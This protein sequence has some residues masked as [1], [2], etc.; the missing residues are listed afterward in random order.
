MEDINLDEES[1]KF[2]SPEIDKG[3]LYGIILIIVAIFTLY[4]SIITHQIW[5]SFFIVIPL[6]YISRKEEEEQVKKS[7]KRRF[8]NEFSKILKFLFIIIIIG[9]IIVLFFRIGFL[10]TA[11]LVLISFKFYNYFSGVITRKRFEK[12]NKVKIEAL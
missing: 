6:L 9:G 2:L 10:V 1:E 12:H 4:I 11:I 5:I 7:L 3:N 8:L